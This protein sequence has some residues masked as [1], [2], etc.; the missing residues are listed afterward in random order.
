ME[1]VLLWEGGSRLRQ[2]PVCTLVK[3][4]AQPLGLE[5]EEG[6]VVLH[7]ETQSSTLPS[8]ELFW[9]ACVRQPSAFPQNQSPQCRVRE[10]S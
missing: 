5:R 3:G 2:G 10:A 4:C 9:G 1:D 6:M 8:S 7:A